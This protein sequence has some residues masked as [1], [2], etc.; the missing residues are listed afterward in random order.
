MDGAKVDCDPS[1]GEQFGDAAIRRFLAALRRDEFAVG[2]ELGWL[3]R[4]AQTILKQ[5][6]TAIQQVG[7][8]L[9]SVGGKFRCALALLREDVCQV[10]KVVE[11]NFWFVRERLKSCVRERRKEGPACCA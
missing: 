3:V 9:E 6:P 11:M 4:H 1:L 2:F 5:T 10:F 8:L 7:V